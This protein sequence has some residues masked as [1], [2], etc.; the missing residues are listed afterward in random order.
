[1]SLALHLLFALLLLP[2]ALACAYLLLL[3]LCSARL[4]VPPSSTG[5]LRFDIVVPAHDEAASI[6]RTLA[7]L[8]RLA[9]P[10]RQFRILVVCDNCTDDTAQ[11]ARQ[12]G[13]C[14]LERRDESRRGK[15]YALRHGFDASLSANWADAVLVIDADSEVTPNLLEACAT[16]LERGAPAVQVHY[17]VLNPNSSLRTRLMTLAFAC[18]HPLRSRARQRLGLSCGI[19]GNGWCLH[20]E[21]LRRI[22]YAAYTLTEDV[23]Y[24]VALGL[25]GCRVHYADEAK[26]LGEMVSTELAARS[27]RRRWE[28][29]RTLLLRRQL[30]ALL[31]AAWR[32][33]PCLDLA[34]DLLLPPL[35]WLVLAA[36]LALPLTVVAALFDAVFT[37]WLWLDLACTA[38]LCL[39]VTRGWRI[40]G[41]GVALLRDLLHVPAYIVWKLRLMLNSGRPAAWVRT[42]RE[43]P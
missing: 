3:S 36:A 13:A 43:Q 9:W 14:V 11:R 7:S 35:S 4:A 37:P 21:T 12:A 24:G 10:E 22:P 19:R 41:L 34:L 29:G 5:R 23:E 8:H 39:Y 27:Q 26:V 20:H 6:A 17:G 16:R 42:T 40:S 31:H 18:I 15:G 33:A 1:M 2:L 28:G 32:S 38:A 30:P 25:A